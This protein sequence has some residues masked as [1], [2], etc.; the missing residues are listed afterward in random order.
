MRYIT[1]I[2][3]ALIKAFEGFRAFVYLCSAKVRTIGYGHALLKGESF[4]NGITEEEGEELL[5][6]D[7]NKAERA[8]IRLTNVPLEDNQFDAL[9]SFVFN[10]G[11]GAYQRSTLRMKINRGEYEDAADE[12]LKWVRAGGKVVKGLVKR[13]QAE[14]E[15]FLNG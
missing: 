3:L 5:K 12:F 8:V 11:A 1:E 13:R 14:R 6:K 9:V 15:L 2:G 4:P 10:L 7:V